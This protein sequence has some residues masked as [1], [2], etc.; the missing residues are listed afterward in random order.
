MFKVRWEHEEDINDCHDCG[1]LFVDPKVRK[2]C[3]I[4]ILSFFLFYNIFLE[5]DRN[6]LPYIF[7]RITVDTAEE[8]FVNP[9]CLEQ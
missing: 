2:V 8:Y 6:Y 9:V 1:V 4:L 7:Y 5:Y 3:N